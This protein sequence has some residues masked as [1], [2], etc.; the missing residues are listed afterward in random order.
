MC[1]G[2]HVGGFLGC[3][4]G[5]G[6]AIWKGVCACLILQKIM[7]A[8][9]DGLCLFASCCIVW[10]FSYLDSPGFHFLW[11]V[12]V[13]IF[14]AILLVWWFHFSYWF[15][16][17]FLH[18]LDIST[19]SISTGRRIS[20]GTYANHFSQD[21]LIL[22]GR[23]NCSVALFHTGPLPSVLPL[24]W[25]LCAYLDQCFEYAGALWCRVLFFSIQNFV[26][27]NTSDPSLC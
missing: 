4:P 14:L 1:L 16:G 2:A 25:L 26:F 20:A 9:L 8:C 3:V 24:E 21:L 17:I 22:L 11:I 12:S 27:S 10:E 7:Q 19:L 6:I 13:W 15:A 5:R 18:I 23:W